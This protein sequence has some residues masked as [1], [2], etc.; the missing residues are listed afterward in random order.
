MNKLIIII[1]IFV[2]QTVHAGVIG[3]D[4]TGTWQDHVA[5]S[6]WADGLNIKETLKG[7]SDSHI[8][9][10][11]ESGGFPHEDEYNDYIFVVYTSVGKMQAVAQIYPRTRLYF[12][13]GCN[14]IL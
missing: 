4:V 6:V 1:I 3:R 5:C 11:K 2:T 12:D 13:M 14:N 8:L 10:A 9:R 7:K